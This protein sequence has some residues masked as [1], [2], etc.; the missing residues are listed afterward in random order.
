[1][2]TRLV[3]ELGRPGGRRQG[4]SLSLA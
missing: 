2:L 3:R 4:G 1:V